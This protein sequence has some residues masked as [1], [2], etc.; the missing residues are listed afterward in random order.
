MLCLQVLVRIVINRNK[1]WVK[2]FFKYCSFVLGVYALDENELSTHLNPCE[3]MYVLNDM[4]FFILIAR[5]AGRK[6]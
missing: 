5:L 2:I 1:N 3:I 6:W 4:P